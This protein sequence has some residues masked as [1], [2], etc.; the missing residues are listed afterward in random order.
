[1]GV[2]GGAPDEPDEGT[3]P[4]LPKGI[5]DYDMYI[6]DN[7]GLDNSDQISPGDVPNA[8]IRDVRTLPTVPNQIQPQLPSVFM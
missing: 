2:F 1:M 3:Q 8:E 5:Q 6:N 7:P 4:Y